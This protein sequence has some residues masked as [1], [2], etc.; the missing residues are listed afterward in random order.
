MSWRF[1]I[2]VPLISVFVTLL[3]AEFVVRLVLPQN[4]D[5]YDYGRFAKPSTLIGQETELLPNASNPGY[6]GVSVETNSVAL[7][8]H[9]IA[10]PKPPGTYRVLTIGDSVTFG[11]GVELDEIY[12]KVLESEFNAESDQTRFEVVNGGLIAGSLSYHYHFLRRSAEALDPDMIMI[13][14]VLND[15]K[16]YADFT[17]DLEHPVFDVEEPSVARRINTLLQD[18]SHLYQMV[19]AKLKGILF[20]LGVLDVNNMLGYNFVAL[21]DST[22]ELEYTWQQTFWV[23]ENIFSL[24]REKGYAV[25]LVVF[26]L[27]VQ[28]NEAALNEYR[29][30]L[31]LK[32][33]DNALNGDPQRRLKEFAAAQDVPY[34]DLLPAFRAEQADKLYLRNKA[35]SHDPVHPSPFGHRIAGQDI[36]RQLSPYIQLPAEASGP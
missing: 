29:A 24:A 10:I 3:V 31:G 34:V 27:E 35:I 25:S 15:I 12:L 11:Y 23:L 20:G 33:G 2:I 17:L 6:T 8:D 28:L 4:T 9:E 14:L 18:H 13:G 19:Y 7:R 22:D 30:K 16:P 26:P 32:L 1:K 36:Y 5:F 21:S